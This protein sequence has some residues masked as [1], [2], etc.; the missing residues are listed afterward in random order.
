VLQSEV[1]GAVARAY[2]WEDLEL[3]H[4]FHKVSYLPEY[5]RIRFTIS[6]AARVEILR[7]L[8]EL[9]RERYQEEVAQGLQDGITDRAKSALRPK[10]P[11]D[12]PQTSFDFGDA[13][14]NQGQYPNTAIIDFLTVFAGWHAKA[15]IIGYI[16]ITDRQWN[17]AIAEL[18][19]GGRVERQ[20]EKRGT[21]YRAVGA[22]R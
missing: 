6:E 10:V 13:A 21:R 12:A 5:D 18:I 9:N 2:G 11:G 4:G 16:N 14:S 8:S 15:D 7:R 1:D 19:S 17:T 3:G 20:G 22:D